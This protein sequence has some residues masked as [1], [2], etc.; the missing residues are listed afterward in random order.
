MADP[1]IS[2]RKLDHLRVSLEEDVQAKGITTGFERYSFLHQALPDM[3]LS[4]VDLSVQALGRKLR[5]PFIISSMTG[6]TELAWDINRHLAAAAQALGIG[7]ALGSERAAI[8]H[9]SL[10]Y[11]Y[12]VREVAPDVLLLANLGA[13]QLNYGYGEEECRRAI[14]NMEADALVLHLNPLQECLQEGGNTNFTGLLEKIATLAKNLPVPVIVKEIGCGLSFLVAQKLVEAGVAG[15][16][17]AG[18]GGTSWSEVERHL[19]RSEEQRLIAE[20]F[21][22]WGISTVDSIIACRKASPKGLVI[23]SGGIRNGIDAAKAIALGADLVGVG[24]PL[25]RPA[26]VSALSV[27]ERI[28][29]ML[30]EMRIAMFCAGARNLAEL[31]QTKLLERPGPGWQNTCS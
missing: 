26:T 12:R 9:P 8:E 7:L 24:R 6:G 22:G 1:P 4:Q 17:T 31:R 30:A 25:L 14:A 29:R 23:G 10:G 5:A 21:A 16:D 2:Q 19:A 18:A 13:V 15:L 20:S 27:Q 11:T 28:E 3:D